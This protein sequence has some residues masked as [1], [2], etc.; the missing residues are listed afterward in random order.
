M[1]SLLDASRLML[2][3]FS[4]TKQR[5]MR[6]ATGVI[7][8]AVALDFSEELYHLAVYSYVLSKILSKPKFMGRM[9]LDK[10]SEIK[11]L[12]YQLVSH[13]QKNRKKEFSSTLA[14]LEKTILD[15]EVP[16][17][18]YI[19]TMVE[20]GKLKTAANLYAHGL[21]LSRAAE[22]TGVEKQEIMD[23]AG[24]TRMFERIEDKVNLAQRIKM[25]S[26]MLTGDAA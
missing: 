5:A 20:K 25:A 3:A 17:A 19:T 22:M 10:R 8:N 23:Y 4:S 26:R 9:Y 18:R 13:A 14:L 1:V 15:V 16:D 2:E 6:K 24:K 11:L 12:L 21:S 7:L